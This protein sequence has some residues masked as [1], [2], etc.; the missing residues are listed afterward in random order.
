[1]PERW[2]T[3]TQSGGCSAGQP[4]LVSC[5]R[6]PMLRAATWRA[7]TMR[8]RSVRS[9]GTT[10]PRAATTRMPLRIGTATEQ[11][12]KLISSTVVA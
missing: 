5:S 8:G 10:K 7:L 12:P 2:E 1:M 9:D 11:L 4:G 6:R 3:M